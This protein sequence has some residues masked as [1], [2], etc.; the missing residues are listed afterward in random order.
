M[1]KFLLLLA[2]FLFASLHLLAQSKNIT[3]K[4]ADDQGNPVANATIVVKGTSLGTTSLTVPA[5]AKTLLVSAVGMADQEVAIG[6]KTEFQID[7][8]TNE[9][10]LEEV[11]VVAYGTAKKEAITGSVGQIKA[12]QI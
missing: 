3:G 1:R 9:Q 5:N 7:L 2:G 11:V 8:K 4:I 6:N 10:S 12:D